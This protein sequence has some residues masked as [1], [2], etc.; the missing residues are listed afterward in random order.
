M[1]TGRSFWVTIFTII[2]QA[3][4]AALSAASALDPTVTSVTAASA[5][6]VAASHNV[7][8][9]IEDKARK[10]KEGVLV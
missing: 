9:A 1:K 5:A 10:E 2:V 6:L 4:L 8:R 7:G 3:V